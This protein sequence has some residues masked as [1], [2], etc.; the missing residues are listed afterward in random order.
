MNP[1]IMGPCLLAAFLATGCG[2]KKK[3]ANLECPAPVGNAF[4]TDG[5]LLTNVQE[6]ALGT[7]PERADSDGDGHGDYV[8]HKA[9]TDP[10]SSSSAPSGAVASVRRIADASEL[11]GGPAAQGQVGDWLLQND[12]IRAIVQRPEAEQMQVGSY[13]GNLV[14][15]DVVRAPG[16]PGNDEMGTLIPFVS[17]SMTSRPDLAVVVNDGSDGGPAILRTCGAEDALEYLD[18]PAVIGLL[19]VNSAFPSNPDLPIRISNDF[20]LAPGSDVVEIVTTI[21]NQGATY[22]FAVG[23][24]LENGSSQEVFSTNSIGYD[25]GEFDFGVVLENQPPMRFAAYTGGAAGVPSGWGYLPS[26]YPNFAV[27]LSGVTIVAQEFTGVFDVVGADPEGAEHPGLHEVRKGGRFSWHRGV[28]VTDGT[29]GIGPY[30][31]EIYSRHEQGATLHAGTAADESGNPLAGV[32]VTALQVGGS[33]DRFPVASTESD[34]N[35]DFSLRLPAGDYYILADKAGRPLPTYSTGTA[36]SI[37]TVFSKNTL[38]AVQVSLGASTA[39]PDLTFDAAATVTVEVTNVDGGGPVASRITV[40]GTDPSPNDSMFRRQLDKNPSIVAYDYDLDGT[41]TF[42]LEP[43]TYTVF[44]SKGI[45]WSLAEAPVTLVA[46]ANTT[47]PL[48]IGKVVETPGWISA[49][50]HVHML[51]SPDSPVTYERR[52][53]NAA[54]EGLDVVVATDHDHITDIGPAITQLGL[55]NEVATV[56][57][58]ET[59]PWNYGHFI[60]YPLTRDATRIDGGAYKWSGGT[61]AITNKTPREIFEEID[62]AHPGTQ[63]KQVAHARSFLNGYYDAIGLDTLTLQSKQDPETLRIPPVAGATADDT[64]LFY[65]EFDAQEIFNGVDPVKDTPELNDL[66]TMLSHGMQIVGTGNSDTHKDLLDPL[67]FPRNYVKVASDA[68]ADLNGAALEDFAQAIRAGRLSFTTGPFL[69]VTVEGGAP[70]DLI[71]AP[72]DGTVTVTARLSMPDWVEVDT[73]RIYMNTPDTI[74]APGAPNDIAPA[75]LIELPI[76]VL[77]SNLTNGLVRNVAT[78]SYDVT[79]PQSEDA[80]IIVTAAATQPGTRS[81]YPVLPKGIDVASGTKAFAL[82]NA[83][84]VDVDGNGTYDAPGPKVSTSFRRPQPRAVR[85]WDAKRGEV[86]EATVPDIRSQFE[87]LLR[88]GHSH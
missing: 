27:T 13:G 85:R 42:E 51:S 78:V 31:D 80:W 49:D 38:P 77:Q 3:G 62:A 20:I 24:V 54:G 40:V 26:A 64:G 19:G 12:R 66:F 29:S 73:L 9:G 5:D 34:E 22:R 8:E 2:D 43:G 75:A 45:E 48:E 52:V 17:L 70:G 11:I 30:V 21:A 86:N 83:V 6:A 60:T 7:N 55:G 81:L 67:G 71:A 47:V 35:G 23:D 58:N 16:E 53:L 36:A 39:L 74:A 44:A 87:E 84:F 37:Q 1:R 76:A 61:G 25:Y 69:D 28:K 72:G 50:F 63:V 59:T 41:V 56:V 88:L 15:V 82:A 33:F 65:G 32:R 10:L 57:G 68:P 79:L 4:D 14:D 46:G 18:V